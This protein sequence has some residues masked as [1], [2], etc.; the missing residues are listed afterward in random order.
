M[1]VFWI[2]ALMMEAA[3]TSE[4]FAD[5]YQTTRRNNSEDSNLYTCCS[6]NLTVHLYLLI[7]GFEMF[8]SLVS[9]FSSRGNFAV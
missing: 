4:T 7:T 2:V 6:D 5:F 1:T 8:I 3:S 9:F